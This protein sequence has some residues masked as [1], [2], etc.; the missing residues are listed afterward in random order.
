[1]KEDWVPIHLPDNFDRMLNDMVESDEPRVGW[2]LL[3]NGPIGGEED[4]IPS[5]NTHN[6]DAG[7]AFEAKIASEGHMR[8]EGPDG[9]NPR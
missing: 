1:M 4:F 3:C 8:G 9:Y 5:T 2:C 7:W 6:C